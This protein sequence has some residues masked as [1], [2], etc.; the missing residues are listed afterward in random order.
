MKRIQNNN[1]KYLIKRSEI[2]TR[3]CNRSPDAFCYMCAH[4]I[5]TK[6]FSMTTSKN[7]CAANKAYFGILDGDQDKT[8]APHFP[9]EHCKKSLEGKKCNVTV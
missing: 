5:K 9:S 7:M 4:L 1:R 3:A 6:K 2:A 8:W